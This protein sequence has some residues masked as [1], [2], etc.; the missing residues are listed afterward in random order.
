MGT[1][2]KIIEAKKLLNLPERAS[3]NEIKSNYRRLIT[4][5]HPDKGNDDI[6]KCHEMTKKLTAAYKTIM[7]YCDQYKYSFTEEEV[8]KY[9]SDEEWW[10][11]RFGTD[12]LWGKGNK[13]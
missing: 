13:S 3:M 7:Q 10:F 12:P 11:E 1:Y 9:L 5:W 2:Q 8:K 6:E 4:R